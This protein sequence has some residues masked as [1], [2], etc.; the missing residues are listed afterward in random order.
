MAVS[1]EMGFVEVSAEMLSGETE[2]T[3]D[4]FMTDEDI[5]RLL[6][7]SPDVRIEDAR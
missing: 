6:A 2:L 7:M 5:A 4:V 1:T 3:L